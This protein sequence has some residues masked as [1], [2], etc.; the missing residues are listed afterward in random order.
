MYPHHD[1]PVG[2][3]SSVTPTMTKTRSF[4]DYRYAIEAG[5][6]SPHHE[7]VFVP[8]WE[9]APGT[10]GTP[11]SSRGRAGK[12]YRGSDDLDDDNN[13]V[14]MDEHADREGVR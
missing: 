6:I 5:L 2:T 10:G 11:A 12:R 14:M 4:E 8:E 13:A 1:Q 9:A 3:P 7:R